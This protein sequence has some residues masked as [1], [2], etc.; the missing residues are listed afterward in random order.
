[1]RFTALN[2]CCIPTP[3]SLLVNDDV[4]TNPVASSSLMNDRTSAAR[5][6]LVAASD[7]LLPPVLL[8][9]PSPVLLAL[10]LAHEQLLLPMITLL[11]LPP[12]LPPLMRLMPPL[13]S[14]LLMSPPLLLLPSLL[15]Q[16]SM[17][18]FATGISGGAGVALASE[19][20][21]RL[22]NSCRS[23]CFCS[24]MSILQGCVAAGA[25]VT[26]AE[27]QE[28]STRPSSGGEPAGATAAAAGPPWYQSMPSNRLSYWDMS[29][30]DRRS[31]ALL[32]DALVG[33]ESLLS[34]GRRL[35]LSRRSRGGGSRCSLRRLSS[36]GR[37]SRS[38]WRGRSGQSS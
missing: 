10:Q 9:P 19:L 32:A 29:A 6:E 15:L 24:A 14:L 23:L 2:R 8:P 17:Q 33:G 4:L 30:E 25:S 11:L 21:R 38:S 16:R 28:L 1:M 31:G 3:A 34:S 12:L 7:M 27:S 13:L 37:S 36:R 35:S 22:R 26:A 20:P 5:G 18:L